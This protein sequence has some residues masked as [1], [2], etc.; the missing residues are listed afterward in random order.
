MP[1]GCGEINSQHASPNFDASYLRHVIDDVVKSPKIVEELFATGLTVESVK[2]ELLDLIPALQEWA[3]QSLA[4]CGSTS[5]PSIQ[6]CGSFVRN[7]VVNKVLSTEEKIWSPMWGLKGQIDI[8]VEAGLQVP[9]SS[10]SQY[11]RPPTIKRAIVPL[12]LK[13]GYTIKDEH[14]AQV[15]LY[16]LLLKDRYKGLPIPGTRTGP[17]P[18]GSGLLLHLPKS[19]QPKIDGVSH[20]HAEVKQLLAIR[21]RFAAAMA[22]DRFR[23]GVNNEEFTASELPLVTGNAN[24]ECNRCF[25]KSICM[26][27]HQ[28]NGGTAHSSGLRE[29]EYDSLVG[30]LTKHETDYFNEWRT[31]LDMEANCTGNYQREIWTL[32]G[33]EREELGRC[34][35]GMKMVETRSK[36][37]RDQTGSKL[38]VHTFERHQPAPINHSKFNVGSY[39][40][41]SIEGAHVGIMTGRIE[42][43][44]SNQLSVNSS[45]ALRIPRQSELDNLSWRIDQDEMFTGVRMV[46]NNLVELFTVDPNTKLDRFKHTRDLV[47]NL[48]PP[49]ICPGG[50]ELLTQMLMTS[51]RFAKKYCGLNQDQKMAVKKVLEAEDYVCIEGM[52]GTGKT[53]TIHAIVLTLQ[54]LGKSVLISSYTHTAV[55]N[56]L[57][58]LKADN[59]D[60]VRLGRREQ[61]HQ[62]LEA[63]LL[64]RPSLEQLRDL[65]RNTGLVVGTTCLSVRHPL[66][67]R[68]AFDY[69]IIDEAGQITQP[70]CL[71]AVLRAKR[72]VLVGDQYQLP[73]LVKSKNAKAKGTN[74]IIMSLF[75][76]VWLTSYIRPGD[77]LI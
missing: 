7:V 8:M 63:H 1:S 21:N 52:P 28:S 40:T 3:R 57:L 58:K 62:D 17:A 47:V 38:Y 22:S 16:S 25:Q 4:S 75:V 71:G 30:H 77:L 61:V 26:L 64:D 9:R 70:V 18:M 69:V 50:S 27:Y 42:S 49:R 14:H 68:K 15:T 37:A 46:K 29:E 53:T 55:D 43:I 31:L 76:T 2:Q 41:L 19:K 74:D 54:E 67:Q 51:P 39:V 12:E 45:H 65:E 72:F 66:V 32:S 13:T 10:R 44:S 33:S 59:I 23:V 20:I 6:F 24:G 56:L 36:A 11:S 34:I 73:P 48:H 60:F 35:S 5:G